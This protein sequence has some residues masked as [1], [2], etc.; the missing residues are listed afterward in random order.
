MR[1]GRGAFYLGRRKIEDT[2]P[3][4]AHDFHRAFIR[5]SNSYFIFHGLP[6]RMERLTRPDSNGLGQHTGIRI[7]RSP[8]ILSQHDR[9][10]RTR[11]EPGNLANV[12]IGQ[13]SL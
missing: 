6:A 3:R 13:K 10:A 4:G 11:L 9:G 2:A 12:S 5:S 1:V 7:P 8:R